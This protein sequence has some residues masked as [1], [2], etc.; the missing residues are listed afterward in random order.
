MSFSVVTLS[1]FMTIS[2][3]RV[4]DD[5]T[6]G[7]LSCLAIA[8]VAAAASI[9]RRRRAFRP[10]GRTG[11]SNLGAILPLVRR[12]CNRALLRE[13]RDTLRFLIRFGRVESLFRADPFDVSMAG[14]R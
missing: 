9:A 8:L 3:R 13:S 14:Y 6:A 4:E 7:P 1:R 5:I 11:G 10:L 12:Q 2:L